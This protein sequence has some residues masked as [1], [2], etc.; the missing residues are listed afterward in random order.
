MEGIFDK[1]GDKE[2]KVLNRRRHKKDAAT[3][4]DV[5]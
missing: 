4:L 3:V 2:G 5:G 1:K